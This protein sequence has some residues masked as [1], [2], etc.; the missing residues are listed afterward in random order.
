MLLIIE[1]SERQ[2][3][4]FI[5]PPSSRHK[6]HIILYLKASAIIL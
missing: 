6:Y 1:L 5:S 2:K 3:E 4:N